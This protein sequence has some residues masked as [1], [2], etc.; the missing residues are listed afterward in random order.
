MTHVIELNSMELEQGL[1]GRPLPCSFGLK[2]ERSSYDRSRLVKKNNF[3]IIEND[4]L[5]E[6]YP[7]GTYAMILR[8][9]VS[10]EDGGNTRHPIFT[11]FP[12]A[13]DVGLSCD[14][15]GSTM[16]SLRSLSC[17]ISKDVRIPFLTSYTIIGWPTMSSTKTRGVAKT[18]MIN[19]GKAGDK[20]YVGPRLYMYRPSSAE[21]TEQERCILHELA[22]SQ[23]GQ[24]VAYRATTIP[25][26]EPHYPIH[27]YIPVN[28]N[29]AHWLTAKVDIRSRHITLY[30]SAIKMTPKSWFQIKNARPLAVLFPYLLMVNEYYTH[31][32]DQTLDLTPFRMTREEDSS[33]PQ[34]IS[35]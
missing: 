27:V 29:G 34:Q 1:I 21:R 35:E 23:P 30:D 2:R 8:F 11:G 9:Q 17:R 10:V 12:L 32:P 3:T 19:F 15:H 24:I 26:R 28:N 25:E 22:Q 33:L 18:Y 16:T 5:L 13:F 7:W 20:Q 31:H 6:K 14:T 4:N